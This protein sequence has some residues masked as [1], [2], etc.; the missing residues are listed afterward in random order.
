MCV[1]PNRDAV[2]MDTL[3][4]CVMDDLFWAERFDGMLKNHIEGIKSVWG[5]NSL[6]FNKHWM[7]I[8]QAG[9]EYNISFYVIGMLYNPVFLFEINQF[10]CLNIRSTCLA[11]AALSLPL[12]TERFMLSLD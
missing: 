4:D 8:R 10:S 1:G 3:F 12:F 5:K 2:G 6:R 11:L 9:L 7:E